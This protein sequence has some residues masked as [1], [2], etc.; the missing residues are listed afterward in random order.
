[1]TLI[2]I[3]LAIPQRMCLSGTVTEMWRLNDNGVTTLTFWGHVT[4]SV[5]WPFD[6]QGSTSY[7]CS[8]VTMHLSSSVMEICLKFF[9]EGSSMNRGRSSASRSILNITLISYT[10]HLYIRKVVRK[11]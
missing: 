6:S 3:C 4:S 2:A 10:P 11:K 1:M 7:G 5:M 9:Q 8:I